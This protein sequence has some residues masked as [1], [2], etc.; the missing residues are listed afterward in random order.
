MQFTDIG[1]FIECDQR[2]RQCTTT[3]TELV[4]DLVPGPGL[5][6]DLAKACRQTGCANAPLFRSPMPQ[7]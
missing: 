2:P 1:N 7:P 6:I 5:E 3:I 4:P